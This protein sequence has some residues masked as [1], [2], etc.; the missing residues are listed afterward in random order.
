MTMKGY[1]FIW[2]KDIWYSIRNLGVVG[3]LTNRENRRVRMLNLCTTV[4]FCLL[5]FYAIYNLALGRIQ[6]ATMELLVAVTVLAILIL[7]AN[8]K[9]LA[10][11]I[12]FFVIINCL[13]FVLSVF[14]FPG[15]LLEYVYIL[16]AMLLLIFFNRPIII[17]TVYLLN[18]GLFYAPQLFFNV[19]SN[20]VFSYTN[21][22]IIFLTFFIL[23]RY[24]IREQINYEKHIFKQNKRLLKLNEE[25]NQLIGIAAHDLKSPLKRIE[26]LMSLIKL[27]SDNLTVEQKGLIE[28][29]SS[30][31]KEQNK[32]ILE[33]L[34]LDKIES[35]GERLELRENNIVE[36]LK[37]TIAGFQNAANNKDIKID[38]NFESSMLYVKGNHKYLTS[39]FE[40]ILSNAIKFS[41]ANTSITISAG[42]TSD[43]ICVSIKDQGPGVSSEDKKKLFGKFQR[44]SAQP[45]GGEVS[46]GLGLAITKKYVE[47]MNAD[48]RC[49]SIYGEGATFVVEFER[50]K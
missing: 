37:D 6:I 3:N 15:R 45:T 20:K 42:K 32:L 8:K 34:D 43:K 13:T 46:T 4:L 25:K 21:P 5:I 29:V 44:L 26:G 24:F 2:M 19:Y 28:K 16:N 17:Y 38:T 7:N 31:S 22:I 14:I 27:S 49:E 36:V 47:A 9:Y 40:N 10:A 39:V 1:S 33:I 18:I 12:T 50:L 30:V 48:I 41:P 11:K 23:M 35:A